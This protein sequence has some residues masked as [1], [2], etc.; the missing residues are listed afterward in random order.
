MRSQAIHLTFIDDADGEIFG[1]SVV[2]SDA[3]PE[4]FQADTVLHI[5]EDDWSVLEAEPMTRREYEA[6]GRLVLRLRRLAVVDPRE[7]LYSLPTLA[8]ELPPTDGPL[9]DGSE[10][11]LHGDDWRQIEFVT[12]AEEAL[13]EKEL[14]VVAQIYRDAQVEDG[15]QA[16]HLRRRLEEP[17]RGVRLT[18]DELRAALPRAKESRVVI[19]TSSQCVRGSFSFFV[20]P[21]L[22]LYGQSVA[23]RVTVLAAAIVRHDASTPGHAAIRE[24]AEAQDLLLVDWCRCRK[25]ASSDPSFEA[26][27]KASPTP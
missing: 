5:G 22:I 24:L 8:N 10:L 9:L 14:D 3:L 18:L 27:L 6:S 15:F 19:E 13:V 26:L 21:P 11:L 4:S 2:E 16:I 25:A 12:R 7:V 1:E 20:T 17:L 23:D